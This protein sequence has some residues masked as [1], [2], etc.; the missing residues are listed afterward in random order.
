MS[1]RFGGNFS[2]VTPAV[3]NSYPYMEVIYAIK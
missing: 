1:M 3:K 2:I